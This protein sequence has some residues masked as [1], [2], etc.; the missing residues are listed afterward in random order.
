M[1]A[2]RTLCTHLSDRIGRH[3]LPLNPNAPSID[4]LLEEGSVHHDLVKTL[5]VAL[6]AAAGCKSLDDSVPLYPVL[7]CLG[8]LRHDLKESKGDVDQL[9][10]ID[11]I[12]KEIVAL[13][14]SRGLPPEAD[15]ANPKRLGSIV[16]LRRKPFLKLPRTAG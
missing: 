10:L 5:V 8:E 15:T 9:R 13:F 1:I 4:E 7:D 12:G 2:F 3:C 14:R 6:Y 16:P 11:D